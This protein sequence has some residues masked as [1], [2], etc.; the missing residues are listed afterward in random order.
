[1]LPDWLATIPAS[2]IF[3]L[4]LSILMAFLTTFINRRLISKE[5]LEQLKAW[6]REISAWTSDLNKAKRTGDKKLLRKVQKQEKRIKQLQMKVAS[7]SLQSMKT[8][9]IFMI[10]F[11]LVWL[12]LTG[13]LLYWQLPIKALFSGGEAVAYLPW[14]LP[15]F[16]GAI[17]ELNLFSW[18]VIGSFAAGIL[19]SRVFGV[20]MGA[21]E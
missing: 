6:Q 19:I 18:Y 8:F 7:Q 2:T 20:G 15:L 11:I 17:L 9:P 5:K 10:L 12:P 1:M 16:D 14:N 3:I 21:T 4:C 13:R